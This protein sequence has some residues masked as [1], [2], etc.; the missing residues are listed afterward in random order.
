MAYKCKEANLAVAKDKEIANLSTVTEIAK[1][2]EADELGAPFNII[3]HEGVRI[4]KCAQ[5]G[6]VL[7]TTIPNLQGLRLQVAATRC[8]NSRKLSPIE[9]KYVRKLCRFKASDIASKLGVS[10]E[11]LSR[12]ESGDRLLSASAEKIFR[13]VVVRKAMP[14]ATMLIDLFRHDHENLVCSKEEKIKLEAAAIDLASRLNKIHEGILEMDLAG[15]YDVED[16]ITL[17]FYTSSDLT[18]EDSDSQWLDEE[19][20]TGTE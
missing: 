12:C 9:L 8:L 6:E 10:P 5:T 16:V 19:I 11:H 13:A 20:R 15:V 7:N 18:D 2:Y 1:V 14:L 3:L 4:T 17:H